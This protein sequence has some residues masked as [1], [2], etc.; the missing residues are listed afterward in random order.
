M[1][2]A[3]DSD[4]QSISA[5]TSGPTQN[6][7]TFILE[8]TQ[9]YTQ[10]FGANPS[11]MPSNTLDFDDFSINLQRWAVVQN[12]ILC[13]PIDWSVQVLRTEPSKKSSDK[14]VLKCQAVDANGASIGNPFHAEIDR[15]PTLE[16]VQ[17]S[18][19]RTVFRLVGNIDPRLQFSAEHAKA[20]SWSRD[21]TFVAPYCV[22]HWIVVGKQLTSKTDSSIE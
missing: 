21:G 10:R 2:D 3:A 22:S 13:Q 19:N 11:L 16:L 6:P 7:E 12:R 8:M 14:I 9:R 4:I 5:I 18:P 20:N 15:S 1:T 17:S